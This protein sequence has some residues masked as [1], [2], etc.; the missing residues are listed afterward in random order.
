MISA[1]TLGVGS[2]LSRIKFIKWG[3]EADIFNIKVGFHWGNAKAKLADHSFNG[4]SAK[5]KMD[6]RVIGFSIQSVTIELK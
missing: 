2:L 4:I 6:H 3:F 1:K 5:M